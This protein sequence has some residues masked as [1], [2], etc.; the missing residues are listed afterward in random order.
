MM[1]YSV[2]DKD[3]KKSES[4]FTLTAAKKCMKELIAQGHEVSGSKTKI[5]ANGNWEPAGE[6]SLTGSNKAFMANT[7]Q[8]KACY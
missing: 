6:I 7:R 2:Y 3:T 1:K 5:W 8:K 4:F